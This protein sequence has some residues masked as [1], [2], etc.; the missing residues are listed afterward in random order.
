MTLVENWS[1]QQWQQKV[2]DAPLTTGILVGSLKG[3]LEYCL[4]VGNGPWIET[5]NC[6][7]AIDRL[8][9]TVKRAHPAREW[10]AD[11][12]VLIQELSQRIREFQEPMLDPY[13]LHLA[14]LQNDFE[15]LLK[16]SLR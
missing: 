11:P 4:R 7:G 16:R 5:Y 8:G 14:L 15:K 2:L 12:V 13:L 3:T 1:Q 6:L 10:D 9:D